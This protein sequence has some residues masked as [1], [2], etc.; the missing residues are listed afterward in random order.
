MKVQEE[1][2]KKARERKLVLAVDIVSFL[3]VCGGAAAILFFMPEFA[4]N[5]YISEN[6]LVPNGGRPGYGH[7]HA[8]F[9]MKMLERMSRARPGEEAVDLIVK[10]GEAAGLRCE[11]HRFFCPI[12]R[13]E[14]VNVVCVLHAARGEGKE[15]VVLTSQYPD[16]AHDDWIASAAFTCSFMQFLSTVPWLSKDILFLFT[17]SSFPPHSPPARWLSDYH[18][19]DLSGRLYHGGEIWAAVSVELDRRSRLE[20]VGVGYESE[21]GQHP[22]LDLVNI[23]FHAITHTGIR[24]NIPARRERQGQ[25]GEERARRLEVVAT[26]AAVLELLRGNLPG[27]VESRVERIHMNMVQQAMGRSTGSHGVFKGLKVEALSLISEGR[28]RGGDAVLS[29][30]DLLRLGQVLERTVRSIN[31]TLER[32]HQ[33]FFLWLLSDTQQFLPPEQYMA[34]CGVLLLP[35]ILQALKLRALSSSSPSSYSWPLHE[36]VAVGLSYLAGLFLLIMKWNFSGHR[37]LILNLLTL[38]M[39]ILLNFSYGATTAIVLV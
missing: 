20:E 8:S 13:E 29:T 39:F 21:G 34:P 2:K 36:T 28:R 30:S 33:S 1:E 14:G 4:R 22:N 26:P 24:A 18:S 9:A 12:T 15:T 17:P 38:V 19:A 31:N 23:A 25:A 35:L 10:I 6:A 32:F 3:L 16:K 5:N 27:F 37:F 7:A 11:K